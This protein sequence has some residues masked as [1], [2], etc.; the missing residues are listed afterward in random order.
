MDKFFDERS[1]TL[2]FIGERF[3]LQ[4]TERASRVGTDKKKTHG[5][6]LKKKKK[7][8]KEKCT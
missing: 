4:K 7:R 1:T 2:K 3:T 8:L 5:D 6:S